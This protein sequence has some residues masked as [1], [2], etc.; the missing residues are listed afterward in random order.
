MTADFELSPERLAKVEHLRDRYPTTRAL[1][2]PML[3]LCQE[4][5]GWLSPEVLAYVARYLGL[6]VAAVQGV[7][8]FYTSLFTHKVAPNVVWVCRTLS[9]ELRGAKRIQEHLEER[10]GCHAGQTSKNGKFTLLKAECLAACGG[11]PVVQIN[12]R[13]YENLTLEALDRILEEHVATSP[14]A[15]ELGL[16]RGA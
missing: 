15:A 11:A 6:S 5:A 2:I 4:Q 10:F 13:Y 12:E 8:T 1:C 3:H 7:A 9:C 14:I 16:G